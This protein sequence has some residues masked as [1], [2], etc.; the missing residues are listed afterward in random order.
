MRPGF[1][2]PS[3]MNPRRPP[4]DYLISIAVVWNTLP[5]QW[6]LQMGE[7]EISK[8]RKETEKCAMCERDG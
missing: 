4:G 2:W 8:Y 3:A 1:V 5:K 7:K 6:L